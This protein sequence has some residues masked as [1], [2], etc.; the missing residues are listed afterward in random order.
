M[1]MKKKKLAQEI[2]CDC[3]YAQMVDHG[4]WCPNIHPEYWS[5]YVE[6]GTGPLSE[7]EMFYKGVQESHEQLV[8]LFKTFIRDEKEYGDLRTIHLGV[9]HRLYAPGMHR[10]LGMSFAN[11]HIIFDKGRMMWGNYLSQPSVRE[12]WQCAGGV[13]RER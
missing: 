7:R 1:Q 2:S 11:Y 10:A 8:G 4:R 9:T 3:G 13:Y 6:A 12:A 5:W